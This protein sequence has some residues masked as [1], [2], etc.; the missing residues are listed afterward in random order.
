[1]PATYAHCRFGEEM[2]QLMPAD[3]RGTANRYRQ[4]FDVGIYGPDLFLF[5]R[6]FGLGKVRRL[7]Q[8]FHMQTGGE[9]FSRACR[10]LRMEPNEGGQAYLYGVLCHF[11]L[12]AR[13]RPLVKQAEASGGCGGVEREFDRF[14]MECDGVCR[15]GE[16]PMTVPQMLN[17]QECKLVSRFYPGTDRK[18]VR[19]CLRNMAKLRMFLEMPQ[20]PV[21]EMLVKVLEIRSDGF[22]NVIAGQ[23]P[24]PEGARWNQP[25]LEQYQQ[26]AEV[27]PDM[28][29]KLIAHLNYNAPLGERFDLIFG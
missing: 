8:K 19:E 4:L 13:C 20:G 24:N 6:L 28:L 14:M 21:R 7:G 29:L 10:N 15:Q 3:V 12:D 5:Y 27:F 22:R 25:L 11:V 23:E 9:F 26:A 1:M 2:L 17:D 18:V 16:I